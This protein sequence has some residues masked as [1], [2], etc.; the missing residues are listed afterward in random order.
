MS[1]CRSSLFC[2]FAL[3]VIV[4]CGDPQGDASEAQHS[5]S[6]EDSSAVQS[7][8]TKTQNNARGEILN[9][10]DVEKKG[11]DLINQVHLTK[12]LSA[13]KEKTFFAALSERKGILPLEKGVYYKVLETGKGEPTSRGCYVTFQ[14]VGKL[15][16]GSVFV[17]RV[18]D[19][20]PLGY[21]FLV[22]GLEQALSAMRVGDEWEVYVPFEQGYA[23]NSNEKIPAYSTLIYT[24]KLQR[25]YHQ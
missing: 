20:I 12:E 14:Y 9:A 4:A 5:G 6:R 7:E 24:V 3:L 23:E 2:L 18:E 11:K 25:I 22:P 13:E 10:I 1:F 17:D 15:L 16:D 21:D 19:M 8:S